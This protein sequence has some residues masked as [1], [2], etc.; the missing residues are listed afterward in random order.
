MEHHS[1][2]VPWQE[3]CKKNQ[4]QLIAIPI[5]DSGELAME[6][7]ENLI[8]E[9]TRLLAL[10]H[11]SNT[12]G[13]INDIERIISLAHQKGIPVLIDAA[14]SIGHQKIDVQ[15]LDCDFLAFSGHK[16]FGPMGIGV[17]YA[18]SSFLEEME[19]QQYGGEM[20]ESVY[21]EASSY[22]APPL[23]FEGGTPNVGGAIALSHAVDYL[24]HIGMDAVT[25]YTQR[26]TEY[27]AHKLDEIKGLKIIGQAKNKG[28]I[29]S[30]VLEDIHPHDIA[31][32]LNEE[33]IAIRAG[34]HCTQPLM[35]F[36]KIPG[37]ARAS[38]ACY[39]TA[40]EIDHLAG[41]IKTVKKIM[42]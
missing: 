13:T 4:A 23:K 2:L 25:D 16:M 17:L 27:A 1:N 41:T 34:H 15:A 26:L 19:P 30:F 31:T 33:G 42:A 22:K 11:I 14:Q 37:T 3:L 10:V 38:F 36:Y 28:S 5:T 39:N 18:K 40:E 8:S 7:I 32:I 6:N 24:Q 29:V 12:L 21:L 9:K 20:V 35:N